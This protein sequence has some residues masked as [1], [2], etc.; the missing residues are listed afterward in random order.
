VSIIHHDQQAIS[1]L[2]RF[3]V[4]LFLVRKLFWTGVRHLHSGLCVQQRHQPAERPDA[5]SPP[6]CT[7]VI[8]VVFV[9]VVAGLL[10]TPC[11]RSPEE[12]ALFL[13][14][15]PETRTSCMRID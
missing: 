10:I 14:Q 8:Y 4:L 12:V 11:P 13:R 3:F 1:H 5:D 6:L 15:L 2:G 7:V 9:T